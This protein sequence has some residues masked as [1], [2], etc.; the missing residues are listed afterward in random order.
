M[1]LSLGSLEEIIRNLDK[2]DLI[3]RIL[4]MKVGE[5][6]SDFTRECLREQPTNK[7]RHI[8]LAAIISQR[9]PK[10]ER[11]NAAIDCLKAD[12]SCYKPGSPNYDQEIYCRISRIENLLENP[13]LRK[14]TDILDYEQTFEKCKRELQERGFEY[15]KEQ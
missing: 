9:S 6:R 1:K 11:L 4:E 10:E 15:N 5:S 13:D 2:D 8:L 12:A 7:L 3:K 14:E